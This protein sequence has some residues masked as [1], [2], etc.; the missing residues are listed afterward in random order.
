MCSGPNPPVYPV[1]PHPIPVSIQSLCASDRNKLALLKYVISTK[2]VGPHREGL[3]A[4]SVGQ[5][6]ADEITQLLLSQAKQHPHAGV[7]GGMQQPILAAG[8]EAHGFVEPEKALIAMRDLLRTN[9]VIQRY[10]ADGAAWEALTDNCGVFQ[11]AQPI[12]TQTKETLLSAGVRPAT[13]M[14]YQHSTATAKPETPAAADSTAPIVTKAPHTLCVPTS[15]LLTEAHDMQLLRSQVVLPQHAFP[16]ETH[17]EINH[18]SDLVAGIVR[19]KHE[20][21][22]FGT[23]DREVLAHPA[24]FPYGLQPAPQKPDEPPRREANA[25]ERHRALIQHADPVYRQDPSF[26]FDALQSD[27]KRRIY[28]AAQR[29]VPSMLLQRRKLTQRDVV[30]RSGKR[31]TIYNEAIS[32]AAKT[33]V[34]GSYMYLRKRR[35]DLMS[36]KRQYGLPDYFITLTA[37]DYGWKE[38]DMIRKKEGGDTTEPQSA[39][40]P[41]PAAAAPDTPDAPEHAQ[42]HD[43]GGE[44]DGEPAIASMFHWRAAQTRKPGYARHA[45]AMSRA[46][47]RRLHYMLGEWRKLATKERRFLGGPIKHYFYRNEF[48]ERTALHTHLFLWMNRPRG[49]PLTAAEVARVRNKFVHVHNFR[50]AA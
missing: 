29:F 46:Y 4:T 42:L 49:K 13:V 3:T 6:K 31:K 48:Q 10:V 5:H 21:I 43:D 7:L 18:Y 9:S 12:T 26:V 39:D 34:R 14:P 28:S 45:V 47:I 11:R 37:N 33:A 20:P 15:Q 1:L 24:L 16:A 17:N 41:E 8:L 19:T 32:Q 35:Q 38:M 2:A 27:E 22:T 30:S 50:C 44:S 25:T 40:T 36:A 23:T